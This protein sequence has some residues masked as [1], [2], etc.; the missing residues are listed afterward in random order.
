MHCP[1]AHSLPRRVQVRSPLLCSLD[2][3]LHFWPQRSFLQSLGSYPLGVRGASQAI[4]Q[5][6]GTQPS[7]A[8]EF[9]LLPLPGPD[10]S[11]PHEGGLILA[12][13]F[14]AV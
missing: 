4:P 5:D 14:L 9:F 13:T 3:T 10:P 12:G 11:L 8:T 2:P 7:Q 1:R 6:P